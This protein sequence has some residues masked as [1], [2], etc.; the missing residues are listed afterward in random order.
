MKNRR[1]QAYGGHD[2]SYDSDPGYVELA[3]LASSA[4]TAA[5]ELWQQT[6]SSVG[7]ATGFSD[8]ESRDFERD[9]METAVLKLCVPIWEDFAH[10]NPSGSDCRD[11][12]DNHEIQEAAWSE[13]RGYVPDYLEDSAASEEIKSFYQL[14]GR[15]KDHSLAWTSEQDMRGQREGYLSGKAADDL[16]SSLK[17][18]ELLDEDLRGKVAFRLISDLGNARLAQYRNMAIKA[19][20]KLTLDSLEGPNTIVEA[21]KYLEISYQGN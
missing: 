5:A 16:I 18:N 21:E 12:R 7:Q 15:M 2:A 19:G 4:T 8:E 1:Y 6:Y 10:W 14:V 9:L 17:E 3:Q 13:V 11:A 20:K